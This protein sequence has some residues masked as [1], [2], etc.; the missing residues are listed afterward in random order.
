MAES[1]TASFKPSPTHL[2]RVVVS[3]DLLGTLVVVERYADPARTVAAEL[4]THGIPVP[5]DWDSAFGKFHVDAPSGA[6]VPLSVHVAEVLSSQGIEPA[7]GAGGSG[8]AVRR[9][10]VAAFDSSVQT[11]QGARK[12]VRAA[13]ERGP[14]GVLSNC[15]VPDLAGRALVRSALDRDPFDAVLTSTGCGWRKPDPLAFQWLAR[16]LDVS[17]G[18]LEYVGVDPD[19]DRGIDAVG[20]RFLDVRGVPLTDLPPRLGP[21]R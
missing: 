3:F 4:V 12:V 16:R 2:D 17:P 14:V 7:T 11:P 20:S 10:V 1:V 18:E 9:A 6:E 21:C 13:A 15:S 8:T 5:K 19:S